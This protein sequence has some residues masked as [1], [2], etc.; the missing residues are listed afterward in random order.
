MATV[1]DE[2]IAHLIVAGVGTAKATD[3]FIDVYPNDLD[4]IYVATHSGGPP[5]T[6]DLGSS[7]WTREFPSLQLRF[8]GAP[9]DSE[10][11]RAKAQTAY[12]AISTVIAKD[13]SGTFYYTANPIQAP[14]KLMRDSDDRTTW[15]FNIN[16]E[17]ELS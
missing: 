7:T 11:P 16:T 9:G 8:R 10:G 1:A 14:F 5:P 3:W 2:I 15:V 13:L 4:V 12:E 17:K 6:R